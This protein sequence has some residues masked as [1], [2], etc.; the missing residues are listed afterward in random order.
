MNQAYLVMGRSAEI[1][2]RGLVLPLHAPARHPVRG[3][4][5]ADQTLDYLCRDVL[6]LAMRNTENHARNTAVQQLGNTLRLTPL[7]DF[8]P[9]YLDP[10]G[11]ART[12]RWHHPR[13]GRELTVWARSPLHKR[14]GGCAN[15]PC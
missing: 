5:S 13:G 9:M 15:C 7:Y 12:A 2:R 4:R 3:D 14:P 1:G 6:N 11:I 10:D 8:A